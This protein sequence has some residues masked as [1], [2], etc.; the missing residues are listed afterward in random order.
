MISDDSPVEANAPGLSK[1]STKYLVN[2]NWMAAAYF[3]YKYLLVL[4][5][6]NHPCGDRGSPSLSSVLGAELISLPKSG[7]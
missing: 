1:D 7:N 6:S 2:L 3:D 4:W 5:T